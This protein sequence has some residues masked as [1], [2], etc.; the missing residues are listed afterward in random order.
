MKCCEHGAYSQHFIFFVTYEW[1]SKLGCLY[2]TKPFWP[3]LMLQ[4]NLFGKFISYE[5]IEVRAW[6]Q[7]PY[8]QHFIFFLTYKWLNKLECLSVTK[9]FWPGVM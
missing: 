3:G 4:S 1:P 6:S 5:E 9:P 8:S 2:V 7:G